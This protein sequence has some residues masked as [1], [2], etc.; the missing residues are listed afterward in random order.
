MRRALISAAAAV[1]VAAAFGVTPVPAVAASCPAL[2]YEAGLSAAASAL[3]KV[4][5]D[6][7]GA[8]H[9]VS[10]LVAAHRASATALQPVLTDL[11]GTPPDV[12]DALLRLASLSAALAYPRGSVCSENADAARAALRDVYASPDFRHLDENSQPGL[13]ATIV[14]AIANLLGRGA[15]A[16][17]PLGAALVAA[18]VLAAALALAWRRWRSGAGLRGAVVEEP[19]APGDDPQAEWRAAERAAAG[20]DYREAVRRAFRSALLDVAIRGHAR[21]DAAWTT[22][23]LL[24][25][26]DA[27]GDILVALAAAAPLFERAWYSGAAVT[28]HDWTRAEKA[29]AAVRHLARNAA[30]VAR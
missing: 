4:P 5:A 22:R 25:R 11:S 20:R 21:I 6:I 8:Q 2:D 17:G 15:G 26:L 16:L 18:A 27:S 9:Q 30:V 10:A 1:V 3:Q 12:G 14:N 13:L 7:A 24:Q 28:R 19:A 29:C 23:E